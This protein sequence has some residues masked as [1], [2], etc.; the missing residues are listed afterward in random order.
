MKETAPK[1]RT[2]MS[3]IAIV[4]GLLMAA[5]IPFLV[6]TSLDRVLQGLTDHVNAGNP[7]FKSG[8][9]IFD[10][11]YPIWRAVIFV[12]G[13]A[14]IVISQEIRKGSEWTFPLSMA[15]FALPAVGGMFMF[16]PYVSWVDGFPLPML[17]SLTGLVGYFSFI[18]LR[19]STRVQKWVRLGALT[20]IGMLSTHAFTIGVGAQRTMMTRPGYPFYQDL[21]WWMF[22]WVGQVNWVAFI[23]LF[24]SIPLLAI[25]RRKGWWFAVIA[26]ISILAINIPTQI[27]RTKTFDYLI[28]AAIAAGVLVFLLVPFFKRHLLV[29]EIEAPERSG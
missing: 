15:L 22:N 28:G 12:A 3:V 1:N 20:F 25:G 5:V 14:L 18:F 24:L 9:P 7:T 26:A 11:F 21:S 27:V 2:I 13:I 23:L 4:I 10:L 8:I 19:Q 17:I 16:L 6:Q 29:E